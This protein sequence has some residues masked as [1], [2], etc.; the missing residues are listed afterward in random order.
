MRSRLMVPV[1]LAVTLA[2]CADRATSS[3]APAT[4]EFTASDG[5]A[6][7]PEL[8]TTAFVAA[9]SGFRVFRVQY[10]LNK[11]GNNGFITF[12]NNASTPGFLATPNARISYH[13]NVVS[14]QG[15]LTFT[16]A[17]SSVF[18]LANVSAARFNPDCSQTCGFFRVP[19]TFYP[20]QGAPIPIK[21][22]HFS[23]GAPIGG[24]GVVAGPL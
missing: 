21:N 16:G 17:G 1:L 18:N 7:P 8:D 6:P 9:P 20:A 13:N 2:A 11:P 12:R 4:A 14:G 10:F 19:G 23:V 15:V 5:L 3:L 24:D 22:G